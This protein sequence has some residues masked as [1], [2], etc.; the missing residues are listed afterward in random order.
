MNGK[1]VISIQLSDYNIIITPN[2]IIQQHQF[3]FQISVME[4]IVLHKFNTKM[5][6]CREKPFIKYCLINN[7]FGWK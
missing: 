3:S 7:R 6:K 4:I 2:F 1:E 5:K